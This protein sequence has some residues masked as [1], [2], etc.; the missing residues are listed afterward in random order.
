ME[1]VS[2]WLGEAL[3]GLSGQEQALELEGTW[4]E[5]S[6]GLWQQYKEQLTKALPTLFCRGTSGCHTHMT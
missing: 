3:G 1:E 2:R 6:E 5:L 4:T